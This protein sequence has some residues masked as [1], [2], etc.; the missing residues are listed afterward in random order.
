MPVH[1]FEIKD[2]RFNI[3]SR[4]NIAPGART[5]AQFPPQLIAMCHG[6]KKAGGDTSVQGVAA[7]W[8]MCRDGDTTDP[9]RVIQSITALQA[10]GS[11]GDWF[12]NAGWRY[13]RAAAV[14]NYTLRKELDLKNSKKLHAGKASYDY[15]DDSYIKANCFNNPLDCYD[16]VSVHNSYFGSRETD[17]H[18]LFT[19]LNEKF[20]NKY[21][22]LMCGFCREALD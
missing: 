17:L 18:A 4:I 22:R 2:T 15:V 16:I 20:S 21:Q 11:G 14:P 5:A 9:D 6:F 19:M 12:N 1:K 13:T 7:A 3:F 8:F 10:N